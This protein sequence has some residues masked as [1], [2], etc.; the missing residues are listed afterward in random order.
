M[1]AE[2]DPKNL[3]L[4]EQ[5]VRLFETPYGTRDN[6]QVCI[7]LNALLHL[8]PKEVSAKLIASRMGFA[9]INAYSNELNLL[10]QQRDGGQAW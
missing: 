4:R 7:E 2:F 6:R 10:A 9:F 3:T 8:L 1:I 5:V